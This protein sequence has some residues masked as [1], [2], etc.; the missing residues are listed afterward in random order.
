MPKWAVVTVNLFLYAYLLWLC[1]VFFRAA[2]GKERILVG[3]WIPGILLGPVRHVL[4]TSAA[5]AIQYIDCVSIAIAFAGAVLVLREVE[6][7]TTL[8]SR[9]HPS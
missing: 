7:A 1:V 4:P 2:Q 8:Q 9:S 5:L 6:H 3:G